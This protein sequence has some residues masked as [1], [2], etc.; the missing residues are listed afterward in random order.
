MKQRVNTCVRVILLCCLAAGSHAAGIQSAR[1]AEGTPSLAVGETPPPPAPPADRHD[2]ISGPADGTPGQQQT[3]T[4]ELDQPQAP[5]E[6]DEDSQYEAEPLTLTDRVSSILG[7]SSSSGN[8][9]GKPWKGLF[10]DNNFSVLEDPA[11]RYLLGE[12]F[13]DVPLDLPNLL[14]MSSESRLSFGGELRHRFMNE[15][16]RLRPGGP[17]RSTYDL[18]RW[19]NYLDYHGSDM[20]RLYVEMLDAAIF[21]EELP[22]TGIDINR[23]NIQN[24]FFDITLPDFSET[25]LTFRAGRQELLYGKQRLVSPLDWGNTRRN[26]EGF[27]VF[28]PGRNWNIDLFTTR[29]VNTATGNGPLS[30]FDSEPDRADQ[31]RTFSGVYLTYHGTK[32]NIVDLYWLWLNEREPRPGFAD[33]S[34]H[35]IGGRWVTTH[36]VGDDCCGPSQIWTTEVEGAYQF[37]TDN[38][39]VVNAGFATAEL[40]LALP[41]L[42]WKPAVKALYYWGSGDSDPNDN[43]NNTFS[44]LFPLG[45]AYWG[46]IDNLSG[47]NLQDYS[48]QAS[49]NPSKRIKI[50]ANM[51]WFDLANR[52]DVLYNVAGVPLGTRGAGTEIGEEFDLVGNIAISPNLSVQIG[53]LWFWNGTFINNSLP[54]DDASQ[55]YVQTTL[56]Y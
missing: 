5:R 48:I 19:R 20:F 15:V 22:D 16:D 42:P 11:H 6:T 32:D 14:I 41:R 25:P 17:G 38:G 31:S 3:V 51:H 12:E 43:N 35:T 33:G 13:K 9:V 8:P 26:F 53:Q 7:L 24:A 27:K 52:N 34:R 1:S 45:H 50:L 40:T 21:N 36:A 54:R 29:P 47:Q 39:Q 46:F 44:V 10:Y 55:F 56:R 2:P 23:F 28:R 30:R 4:I 18:W 37:G 49:V